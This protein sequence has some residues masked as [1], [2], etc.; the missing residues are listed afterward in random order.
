MHACIIQLNS[1]VDMIEDIILSDF[2]ILAVLAA[3][4]LVVTSWAFRMRE[5]PGYVLGWLIGIFFIIIYRALTGDDTNLLEAQ[6]AAEETG[7]ALS[8]FGVVFPTMLGLALGFGVMYFSKTLGTTR[9]RRGV[10]IAVLTATMVVAIFFLTTTPETTQR[11]IGIFA[12][13]FAIGALT[14]L[15]IGAGSMARTPTFTAQEAEEIPQAD[16]Q[17]LQ[18]RFDRLR[19]RIERHND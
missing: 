9:A 12:L 13:A 1:V 10:T 18:S 11:M 7:T 6:E 14:D 19:R 16:G 5:Y 8:F 15:V 17:S 3:M 4:L 2:L